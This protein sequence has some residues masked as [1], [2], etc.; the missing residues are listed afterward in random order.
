MGRSF[1][2]STLRRVSDSDT[3]EG[4]AAA[5]SEIAAA[6]N[7]TAASRKN[8][9]VEAERRTA[10]AEAARQLLAEE[11]ERLR[12]QIE[13][14]RAAKCRAFAGKTPDQ[15]SAA[16]FQCSASRRKRAD[17]KSIATRLVTYSP[18][19][20]G[21]EVN[22]CG[23]GRDR[24][25]ALVCLT[26]PPR[27]AT[28]NLR[29]TT[30]ETRRKGLPPTPNKSQ[31]QGTRPAFIDVPK[32]HL[33]I[34]LRVFVCQLAARV[35]SRGGVCPAADQRGESAGDSPR[36]LGRADV[37]GANLA[38]N[39]RLIA[40]F[41]F[42]V[43]SPPPKGDAS[44]WKLALTADASTPVGIYPVRIQ[45]DDGISNPFLLAIGQ[46]P[47]IAEKEDNSTFETAQKVPDP[48]L[49][50]EG[51]VAGNDVDFFRF[52]GKKGQSILVD[53]QCARLGR[54]LT[55]ASA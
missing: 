51:Q 28:F 2:S 25:A 43:D 52:H 4:R 5:K 38:G 32:T 39:P 19:E 37:N 53:A 13:A 7:E 46:L 29:S 49:V 30:N 36:L 34:G 26:K 33:C 20:T 11:N 18:R 48:P 6:K 24:P 17:Q 1:A 54:A 15:N 45:T 12:R 41:S 40:P 35:L 8:Q 23:H 31:E 3:V 55:R 47:Q 50:M 42:K 10:A 9:V 21:L 22:S 14:Q 44:N 16:C 27:D